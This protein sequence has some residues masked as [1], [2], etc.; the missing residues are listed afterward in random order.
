MRS[1][2]VVAKE[3]KNFLPRRT[4]MKRGIISIL[5]FVLGLAGATACQSDP[6]R[7][8]EMA[9]AEQR[10]ENQEA[11]RDQ[12]ELSRE[13]RE[14][15]NELAQDQREE[16][17]PMNEKIEER[18]E[19]ARDQAEERRDLTTDQREEQVENRQDVREAAKDSNAD[20]REYA[21]ESRER[22]RKAEARVQEIRKDG[23]PADAT[24]TLNTMPRQFEEAERDTSMPSNRSRRPTG[25]SK[26]FRSTVSSR[27]SSER[28]IVSKPVSKTPNAQDG[29]S[30]SAG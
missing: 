8:V 15:R 10:E 9:Q 28:S 24:A 25:S 3:R 22:L 5:P 13:Q 21:R 1:N 29:P 18:N 17:E 16:N 27:A 30:C 7:K 26:R 14:E 23:V 4:F 20:K 12:A 19:L 2:G 6:N 11:A